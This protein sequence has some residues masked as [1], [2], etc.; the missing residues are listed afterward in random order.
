MKIV[1]L[2]LAATLCFCEEPGSNDLKKEIEQA[3]TVFFQTIDRDI[4]QAYAKIAD[5]EKLDPQQRERVVSRLK[6][7]QQRGATKGRIVGYSAN[8]NVAV[9]F[10]REGGETKDSADPIYLKR[11]LSGEWKIMPG[12]TKYAARG[13]AIDEKDKLKFDSLP[14]TNK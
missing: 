10:V 5:S 6:N 14:E 7:L 12:I 8:D 2:L 9:V 13:F 11:G 1:Y 4:E 3:V